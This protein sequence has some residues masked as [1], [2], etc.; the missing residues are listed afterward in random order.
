M[1]KK[2]ESSAPLNDRCDYFKTLNEDSSNEIS[3]SQTEASQSQS[4]ENTSDLNT[5]INMPFTE[6]EIIGAVKKQLQIEKY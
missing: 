4:L 1:N 5:D 6:Y 3:D 2:E